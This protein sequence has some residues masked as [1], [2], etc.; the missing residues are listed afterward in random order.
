MLKRSNGKAISDIVDAIKTADKD[1]LDAILAKSVEELPTQKLVIAAT[2]ISPDTREI[3]IRL[4]QS[5]DKRAAVKEYLKQC[6]SLNYKSEEKPRRRKQQKTAPQSHQTEQQNLFEEERDVMKA[7]ADTQHQL[8]QLQLQ[9]NSLAEMMLPLLKNAEGN[10]HAVKYKVDSEIL[11]HVRANTEKLS[12]LGDNQQVLYSTLKLL[13]LD[14]LSDEE[15][16]KIPPL[17][18]VRLVEVLDY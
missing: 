3:T 2:T 4:A 18:D 14:H 7:L 10:T 1:K 8:M 9:L 11:P 6:I 17:E 15:I 16:A 13:L 12:F 5:E